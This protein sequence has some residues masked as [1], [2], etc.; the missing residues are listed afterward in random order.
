MG[1]HCL[2]ELI[3]I[4][5]KGSERLIAE[6]RDAESR[7]AQTVLVKVNKLLAMI[8]SRVTWRLSGNPVHV[9]TGILRSSVRISPA[10]HLGDSIQGAVEAGDGP[11][12]YGTFVER[13]SRPHQ[14]LATKARALAFMM[15]GRK[16]FAQRVFHPGV[17]PRWFM[18]D[19]ADEIRARIN[20]VFSDLQK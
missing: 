15:D 17:A 7:F 13:G 5:L 8:A 3:K 6:F 4:E 14:I 18:R 16:V 1:G 11:A 2:S 9:R 20:E 10:Q 19:T 12:F